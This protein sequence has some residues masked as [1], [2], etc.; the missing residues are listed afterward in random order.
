MTEQQTYERKKRN[1]ERAFQR[2]SDKSSDIGGTGYGKCG[3]GAICEYCTKDSQEDP[4]IKAFREMCKT[5]G[6]VP[7][8][9]TLRN[10]DAWEGQFNA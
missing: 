7:D 4:C 2:W 1:W 3:C 8:Y 10:E 5:E 6:L 9:E